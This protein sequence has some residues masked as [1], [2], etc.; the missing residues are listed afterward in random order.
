MNGSEAIRKDREVKH[1][2]VLTDIQNGRL[3][4]LDLDADDPV[5]EEA[6]LWR[7]KPDPALGW[8]CGEDYH[9]RCLSGVK[10]RWSEYYQSE[11]VLM[12]SSREWVG[13]AE[14][15]SG[16]CLWEQRAEGC[17]HSMELLPNGDVVVA[18][19]GSVD[20]GAKGTLRY[21]NITAG[22][23]CHMTDQ[24]MFPGIHG[25][26]WDPRENLL[27]ALGHY[28]LAAYEVI[29]SER[30]PKLSLIPGRGG[31]LPTETGHNLSPD[32]ADPDYLWIS[33][34]YDV[35][36]F[37]KSRNEMVKEYPLCEILGDL[38]KTKGLASFRDGT[39]A[40]ISYGEGPGSNYAF[41]DTFRAIWPGE[42]GKPE[43][44]AYTITNGALWNKVRNF[45]AD[46]L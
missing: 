28:V 34:Q 3:Y 17:P 7:W 19:S 22:D 25:V 14:Y 21:F 31:K 16:K 13:I 29:S 45:T 2:A 26:L 43:Q 42:D 32:Y 44:K 23:D 30:G 1:H 15:P 27:W 33:T 4:V 18:A 6:I 39:L 41:T 8:Q 11:V 40:Y 46:Y 37:C 35:F 36:K 12:T 20:W 24:V 10:L 5:S 9:R 38:K